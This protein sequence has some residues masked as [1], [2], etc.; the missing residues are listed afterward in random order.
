VIEITEEEM[1][2]IGEM[3]RCEKCGHLRAVHELESI[4]EILQCMIYSCECG[5]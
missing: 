2:L 5:W 1:S 4:E 3:G